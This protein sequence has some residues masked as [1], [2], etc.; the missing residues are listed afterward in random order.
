MDTF[1]QKNEFLFI[2]KDLTVRF[3]TELRCKL[4]ENS[5]T[6]QKEYNW[7]Y[8]NHNPLPPFIR[9]LIKIHKQGAPIRP[10]INWKEAPAY[11]LAKHIP[12]HFNQLLQLPYNF[13]IQNVDK[14]IKE[15]NEIP[16]ETEL[17]FASF[18]IQNMYTNIPTTKLIT[19]IQNMCRFNNIERTKQNELIQQCNIVIHQNYFQLENFQYMQPKGLA[20]GAPTSSILP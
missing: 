12:K 7:K 13:N 9:G 3:H 2:D 5:Q 1:I 17:R 11:K 15:M 4:Y 10:V 14:L 18:H 20:M 19:I 8:I 16:F 6:I